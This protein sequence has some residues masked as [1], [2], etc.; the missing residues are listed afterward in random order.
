MNGTFNQNPNQQHENNNNEEFTLSFESDFAFEGVDGSPEVCNSDYINVSEEILDNPK[1]LVET[2]FL[3]KYISNVAASMLR[4]RVGNFFISTKSTFFKRQMAEYFAMQIFEHEILGEYSVIKPEFPPQANLFDM[5]YD[6][7]FCTLFNDGYTKVILFVDDFDEKCND[8]QILSFF[9]LIKNLKEEYEF[10]DVRILATTSST[11]F[12]FDDSFYDEAE[13]KYDIVLLLEPEVNQFKDLLK[14]FAKEFETYYGVKLTPSIYEYYNLMYIVQCTENYDMNC[15]IDALDYIFSIAKF[16]NRKCVTKSDVY[17]AFGLFVFDDIRITLDEL[18]EIAYHEAG[19]YI[20][21][22]ILFEKDYSF[23]T[24][25]CIPNRD[26]CLGVTIAN[27]KIIETTL[28]AEILKKYIAYTL[29]GQIAEALIGVP[30]NTGSESDLK[31][32]KKLACDWILKSGTFGEL[33]KYCFY[34]K[35]RISNKKLE[36]VEDLA[37]ELIM[38]ASKLCEN[39]LKENKAFLD[40]IAEA[41][42]KKRLLSKVDVERIYKKHFPKNSE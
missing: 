7:I 39:V 24:M 22:R 42:F 15:F 9:S 8:D 23:T 21:G 41:L 5:D 37:K 28:N 40:E 38:D 14:P 18:K 19:H 36:I 35:K 33:G 3:K 32:A 31:E 30:I 26:K 4:K 17:N 27:V 6:A 34:S 1:I 16:N 2:K 11:E 13:F 10:E 29:G 25:S 12:E 20:V